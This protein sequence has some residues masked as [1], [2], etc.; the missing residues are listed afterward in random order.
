MSKSRV[1]KSAGPAGEVR[2]KLV[3]MEFHDPNVVGI[4][5]HDDGRIAAY[6]PDGTHQVFERFADAQ[7]WLRQH[8]TK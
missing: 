8:A 3:E 6:L 1:T 5:T 2:A 7:S 4:M